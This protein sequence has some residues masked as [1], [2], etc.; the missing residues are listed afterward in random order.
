MEKTTTRDVNLEGKVVLIKKE[1]IKP[2]FHEEKKRMAYCTGGFGCAPNSLG[3]K[4]FALMLNAGEDTTWRREHIECVCEFNEEEQT[5]VDARIKEIEGIKEYNR[6][7]C[8]I[9][10]K[11]MTDEKSYAFD[12]LSGRPICKECQ[13]ARE[14]ELEARK[15]ADKEAGWC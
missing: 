9:C 3:S 12:A 15:A 5:M 11:D 7:H 8:K 14:A 1:A 10:E 13:D 6:N 4:V 2:E